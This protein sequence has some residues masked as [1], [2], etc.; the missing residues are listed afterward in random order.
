MAQSTS[1]PLRWKMWF[2]DD[3][4]LLS[5]A[6]T[7]EAQPVICC[8]GDPNYGICVMNTLL[9]SLEL[10]VTS[11]PQSSCYI[12]SVFRG[13]SA[14]PLTVRIPSELH[15]CWC[16]C[17]RIM[18]DDD[19]MAPR[20]KVVASWSQGKEKE[21]QITGIWVGSGATQAL[22]A[23]NTMLLLTHV[24]MVSTQELILSLR[25]PP[26]MENTLYL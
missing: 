6:Q 11:G 24:T 4:F 25:R 10:E 21:E 16:A 13:N 15:H 3:P 22:R 5:S 17:R 8:A 9:K 1:L 14:T 7:P 20:S 18:K 2:I 19:T 23:W 12:C 26:S